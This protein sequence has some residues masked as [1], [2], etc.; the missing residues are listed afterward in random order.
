MK[1]NK[2]IL[3]IA[4]IFQY[5]YTVVMFMYS[6]F[7]CELKDDVIANLFLLAIGLIINIV[8]HKESK[9]DISY[10]KENK[11]KVLFCGIYLFLQTVIPGIL[12]FMFLSSLNEKKEK[13]LPII[14]EKDTNIK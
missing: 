13:K 12:V 10:L 9:K 14:K 8:L 4:V 11:I 6:I 1:N 7:F 3:N 2:K 5:I